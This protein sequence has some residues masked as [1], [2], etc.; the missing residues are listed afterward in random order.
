MPHRQPPEVV[1]SRANLK[2]WKH[3]LLADCCQH[4]ELML[5]PANCL[6]RAQACARELNMAAHAPIT[7][8][9]FLV[10]DAS[11]SPVRR[12]FLFERPRSNAASNSSKRF[13]SEEELS[14]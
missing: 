5:Y 11:L 12:G 10:A 2:G 13:R 14:P 8:P 4:Q 1:P 9:M 6:S 7:A 3:I